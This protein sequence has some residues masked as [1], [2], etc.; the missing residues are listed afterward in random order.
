MFIDHQDNSPSVS[1]AT[2]YCHGS[3]VNEYGERLFGSSLVGS[4]YCRMEVGNMHQRRMADG[5]FPVETRNVLVDDIFS[6][7][8]YTATV[9]VDGTGYKVESSWGGS[10]LTGRTLLKVVRLLG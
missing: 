9:S 8:P 7:N 10:N 2:I 5:T 6:F 1:W 4:A 3:S